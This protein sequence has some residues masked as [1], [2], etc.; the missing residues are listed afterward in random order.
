MNSR[1]LE[2]HFR[3]PESLRAIEGALRERLRKQLSRGKVECSLRFS[4]LQQEQDLN[5]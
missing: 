4:P 5:H 3:L 1:Y 2:M